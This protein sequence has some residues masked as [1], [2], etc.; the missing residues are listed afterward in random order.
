MNINAIYTPEQLGSH[1]AYREGY[2][3]GHNGDTE[4]ANPYQG[5]LAGAWQDGYDDGR[6]A[7][8]RSIRP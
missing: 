7:H 4:L 5:Y 3:A 8:A 6:I 1:R 2:A